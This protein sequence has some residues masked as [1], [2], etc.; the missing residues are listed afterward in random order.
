MPHK[1]INLRALVAAVGITA[2][3]PVSVL[4]YSPERT[5]YTIEKP[6]DHITFNS[7]T[8]NPNY[9]DERNFM[10][11]KP[12]N[13]TSAGGWSDTYVNV[14]GDQEFLMR[15]YV[16]NN[17]AD[18]LNLVA[19][20]TR[21]RVSLPTTTA[22]EIRTGAFISAS[23]ATPR[24]V[25]DDVIFKSDSKMFNIAYVAG[26]ARYY[27]NVN[28]SQGFPISDSLVTSAGA[29]IGY[30]QMD[31]RLRGCFQYSGILTFKVKV[32]TQ[33]SAAFKISKQVRKK[34]ATAWSNQITA[35]PGEVVE[36]QLMYENVGQATQNGVIVKDYLPTGVIANPASLKLKNASNPN[37]STVN[38]QDVLFNGKGLII[39]N[40]TPNSNAFMMFAATMPK[41]EDLK[42][43]GNNIFRNRVIVYTPEGNLEDV[44]DV[45]VAK[46]NCTPTPNTPTP[47]TPNT[48]N[49]PDSLPSTGPAEIAISVIGLILVTA[50]IVYWYKSQQE[51]KKQA[52]GETNMKIGESESTE[53][54]KTDK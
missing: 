48:P 6:A 35:N 29:T 40:Y 23:N 37:G 11:A 20:N 3:L 36:Y 1:N 15:V 45:V 43:C 27:N 53:N 14:T 33:K 8:N 30:N 50:S 31:G 7:I 42:V 25:Y 9:G 28:P 49:T 13:N 10:L 2:V 16:H 54:E 21:V 4:A 18:N 47:N 17:A 41:N 19:D 32:Q 46:T 34:G 39:G 22:K 38:N 24:E 5:T 51:L 26:S 44:A 12:S 52:A